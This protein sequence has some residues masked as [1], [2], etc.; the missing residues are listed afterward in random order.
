MSSETDEEVVLNESDS[1]DGE[2][3]PPVVNQPAAGKRKLSAKEKASN[4]NWKNNK[5]FN[6]PKDSNI[7]QEKLKPAK[8]FTPL[9]PPIE[10]VNQFLTNEF[11]ENVAFQ[12]NLYITQ[13]T[14]TG[15]KVAV[16]K[17]RSS[18]RSNR[19]VKPVDVSEM[20]TFIG[21]IFYMGIHKLP[22]R[23]L[24]WGNKTRVPLIVNAMSRKRFEEVLSA[25]Y[26]NDNE[27]MPGKDSPEYDRMFK[28]KPLLDHFRKVFADAVTPETCQAVDEMM[29][30]FKGQHSAKVYMP[31]KPVK[32]GYK[33]WSRAGV[34]GYVY[35]F[36]VCG[37]PKAKGPPP[38]FD[39]ANQYGESEFV[40]LRMLND[41]EPN[42]HLV[43][44]DNLFSSPELLTYL[45]TKQ[46][47]S[48][49]H[50]ASSRSRGCKLPSEKE[51]E[52]NGRGT[53]NEFVDDKNGLVI[54]AW[55]DNRRVLTISNFLGKD[56]VDE[57]KRY[58]KAKQESITISRP[59][60]V[61]LYNTFM[62]GVDKADM[63]L[64]LYRT[65]LRTR[66]W[67]HRIAFHILSLSVV[68]GFVI[69]R[70]IGGTGSLLDFLTDVCRCLITGDISLD[71]SEEEQPIKKFRSLKANAVPR[72]VRLDKINHWPLQC[73]QP[74]RCK[75]E[76]CGRRT[77]FIC[78]KC[79]VYLCVT[80]TEC[81]LSF[82]GV[83][84]AT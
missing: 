46:I 59:A 10:F 24:H 27:K 67:Y 3:V 31:K 48:V 28:L 68:N 30:P 32:W 63:F 34:S 56:P 51:M 19:K 37:E 57:A 45:K 6:P 22:N 83:A 42:K 12:T 39:D 21:I 52:K 81:F 18:D 7:Q 66:K 38:N 77:R 64:S 41:L 55:F 80:G 40:V 62:G 35:N 60:S 78:S 8:A 14:A 15:Y 16:K 50:I 25:L 17:R 44:F 73:D 2:N 72:E 76:S 33:L 84:I 29:V 26:F 43:F 36:E 49:C 70:E 74:Q 23:R 65:K 47:Y 82:H 9:S 79:Q 20:R 75:H 58:D 13:R 1:E 4:F 69:Y 11:L 54:C 71:D 5:R 53:I 61:S